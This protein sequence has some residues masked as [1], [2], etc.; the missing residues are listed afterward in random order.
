MF[1]KESSG[2]YPADPISL[3]SILNSLI[4]V[5]EIDDVNE[6]DCTLKEDRCYIKSVIRLTRDFKELGAKRQ[7]ITELRL[8]LEFTVFLRNI[9]FNDPKCEF[10]RKYKDFFSQNEDEEKRMFFFIDKLA[11]L[12]KIIEEKNESTDKIKYCF[13]ALPFL[14]LFPGDGSSK[15]L[16]YAPYV[17]KIL[18]K[19][20]EFYLEKD[21]SF[22]DNIFTTLKEIISYITLE[23]LKEKIKDCCS[24]FFALTPDDNFIEVSKEEF[25]EYKG[26]WELREKQI[27]RIKEKN[28]KKTEIV[29]FKITHFVQEEVSKVEPINLK[30]EEEP[31]HHQELFLPKNLSNVMQCSC[32][33]APYSRVLGEGLQ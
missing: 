3:E 20:L 1:S 27:K 24:S 11:Q 7:E 2:I 5:M 32:L 13:Y 25:E 31:P 19:T 15:F 8:L 29:G 18:E 4:L 22:P 17:Y 16:P 14:S 10:L 12:E 30:L 6:S 23:G 21:K 33:K 26:H 28:E 9:F